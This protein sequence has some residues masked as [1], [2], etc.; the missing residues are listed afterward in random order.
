MPL[1]VTKKYLHRA[2]TYIYQASIHEP[3]INARKILGN[4]DSPETAFEVYK[5]E[6]KERLYK[7]ALKYYN[8]NA[9]TKEIF[10]I[11]INLQIYPFPE[12][13]KK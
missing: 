1:G 9:I 13:Y 4:F 3:S 5:A 11:V 6:K 12:K 2:K 7:L 10:D 8:D